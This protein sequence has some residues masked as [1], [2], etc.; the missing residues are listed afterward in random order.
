MMLVKG[1]TED[2]HFTLMS[3][4]GNEDESFSVCN[5]YSSLRAFHC[6]S[7]VSMETKKYKFYRLSES[8]RIP[9]QGLSRSIQSIFNTMPALSGALLKHDNLSLISSSEFDLLYL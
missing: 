2:A 9:F 3:S 6:L 4:R 1:L 7:S 5:S 8:G